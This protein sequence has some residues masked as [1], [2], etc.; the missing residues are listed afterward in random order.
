MEI[1]RKYWKSLDEL[2]ETETF[3]TSKENEFPKEMST[4]EFL[5]E[6]STQLS[7]TNRRDFLKFLGFSIAAATVAACEAPV[8]KAVPYLNKPENVTPGMATWY[9]STYYDGA[10]Y[11]SILVKTR[12]G[13]PIHIKGNKDF[14]FTKGNSTPQIIASVLGLYDSARLK[15]PSINGKTSLW[16]DIDIAVSK[17]IKESNSVTLLTGTVI[18][19]SSKAAITSL[20]SSIENNGQTLSHIEYDSISYNAIRKANLDRKSVV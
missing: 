4:E 3:L 1:T 16:S 19:P 2:N 8:I 15:K 20:K 10:T 5:S 17:A 6:D 11:A 14:G 9:A 7:S 12:E 18:S 13:R